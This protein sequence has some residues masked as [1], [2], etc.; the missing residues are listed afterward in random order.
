MV[1]GYGTGIWYRD[2]IQGYGTGMV[3]GWYTDGT[4]IELGEN[5]DSTGMFQGNGTGMVQGR[6]N[7][8]SF[9]LPRS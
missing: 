6:G 3:Q 5:R 2:M 4:G 9:N 7:E 1:Q 8:R